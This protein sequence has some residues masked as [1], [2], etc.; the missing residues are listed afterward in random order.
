MKKTFLYTLFL[1][2]S[3]LFLC[4][5]ND[6]NPSDSNPLAYAPENTDVIVSI[7]NLDSFQ[8]ELE[9]NNIVEAFDNTTNELIQK[10]LQLTDSITNLKQAYLSYSHVG[11]LNHVTLFG[12][13]PATFS[14]L[15]TYTSTIAYKSKSYK[16]SKNR[17]STLIDSIYVTSTSELEIQ[18]LIERHEKQ[19]VF[20]DTE[21]KK[22]LSVSTKEIALVLKPELVKQFDFFPSSLKEYCKNWALFDV[23]LQNQMLLSNITMLDPALNIEQFGKPQRLNPFNVLPLSVSSSTS[24]TPSKNPDNNNPFLKT[25]DSIPFI[26]Q[27]ESLSSVNLK[28]ASYLLLHFYEALPEDVARLPKQTSYR[29]NTIYNITGTATLFNKPFKANYA[30]G[31]ENT[32]VLGETLTSLEFYCKEFSERNTLGEHPDF[33]ESTTYLNSEGHM[34][35]LEKTNTLIEEKSQ[36]SFPLIA[37]QTSFENGFIQVNGIV[38]EYKNTNPVGLKEISNITLDQNFITVPQ[39]VTNHR[40]FEKELVIQDEDLNLNLLSLNGSVL[41]KKKLDGKIQGNI[42]QVDLYKNNKLQYAFCTQNT[43]Y[44]LDRNGNHVENFPIQFK[45]EITQPLSVFDY[46]KNK[47]YR[48]AIVQDN[49]ILLLNN[50]GKRV[51]GF[52]YKAKERITTPPK[53]FR[54][55]TKDYIAF[56]TTTSVKILN[57]TGSVRVPVK[58]TILSNNAINQMEIHKN[59]FVFTDNS[60]VFYSINLN[61]KVSK[62]TTLHTNASVAYSGNTKAVLSDNK[63]IVNDLTITLPFGNYSPV[64]ALTVKQNTF[65]YTTNRETNQLYMY[66]SGGNL[67]KHFPLFAKSEA[68]VAAYKKWLYIS[69]LI[70]DD[71]IV[72][73][74]IKL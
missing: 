41:W 61:G 64:K 12:K 34:F 14:D 52:L 24:F 42:I 2:L 7:S 16:T 49:E 45:D 57:R 6:T 40:N 33:K 35:H 9:E 30:V 20:D 50:K 72:V 68:H 58:E 3:V 73:Y 21:V 74:G 60:G 51:K 62:K 67:L 25:T 59:N 1:L 43:L 18:Q 31:L 27:V 44:V 39:M 66:D 70:N 65:V 38:K 32:L 17:F 23:S 28:D 22:L 46:D 63:L 13:I 26:E 19:L 55:K 69:S 53:H 56:N 47:K 29:G 48:F 15:N 36:N 54:I 5:T 10:G 71:A 8:K 4:C 11:E 37:Y